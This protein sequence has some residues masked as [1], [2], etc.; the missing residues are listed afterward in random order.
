MTNKV[1]IRKACKVIGKTLVFRDVE[2]GD[3]D[4]I[5]SLRCDPRKSRY[6]SRTDCDTHKQIKWI[7]EYGRRIDEAYF[8]I[9]SKTGDSLGTVRIYDP[10]GMSFSW[11]SWMLKCGSPR[12]AAI[13]SA[14]MVYDYA[15][16]Y[17][18]FEESH[19]D[20][21]KGNERVW[22]FHERFGAVR[23][24]ETDLDFFYKISVAEIEAS[25]EKYERYLPGGVEVVWYSD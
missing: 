4:F 3:A 8:V 22:K 10:V 23:T 2:I 11:G 17:L 13:E 25:I 14:L 20:V 19:F 21:R 9:E 7:E 15:I 5:L 24:G 1:N 18:G 6:I 12:H 16:N